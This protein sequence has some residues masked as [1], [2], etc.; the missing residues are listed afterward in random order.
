MT[1]QNVLPI[2]LIPDLFDEYAAASGGASVASG[3]VVGTNL[4]LTMS[5]ATSVVV[6]L[7]AIAPELYVAS[8]AL[9][10]TNLVLTMSDGS[11]VTIDMTAA[12]QSPATAISPAAANGVGAVGVSALYAREDHQHPAQGVSADAGNT[13]TIGT[14]GL[15]YLAS[16]I[17][18]ADAISPASDD[19]TGAIGVVAEAA[20]ED[21][22]HPA[23]GVS[24]DAGNMLTV[25]AD[26]LHNL[27]NTTLFADAVSPAADDAAG[28]IGAVDQAA[29]EDH[30]HPAQGVS[31]DAGNLLTVGTDGLHLFNVDEVIENAGAL[32]GA[33]PAGAQFGVDTTTGALYYVAAGNWTAVPTLSVDLNMTVSSQ[34]ASTAPAAPLGAPGAPDTGDIHLEIYSDFLVWWSWNGAAWA[35][36]GQTEIAPMMATAISP[37]ATNNVGAVGTSGLAAR[38]DH[39]HPAQGVSADANQ[40]ITVGADGLHF[41]GGDNRVHVTNTAVAPAAAGEPTTAEIAAAVTARDVI[42][43]YTGDDSAASTPTR[44]FHVDAAGVATAIF[45]GAIT[46]RLFSTYTDFIADAATVFESGDLIWV[47]N[48]GYVWKCTAGG[49]GYAAATFSLY[50]DNRDEGFGGQTFIAGT[51]TPD[52]V[53]YGHNY[54]YQMNADL[55]INAMQNA[56]GAVTPTN[57]YRFNFFIENTL[58]TAQNIIF[59]ASYLDEN[60]AALGTVPLAANTTAVYEF[61]AYN[62]A[63][64]WEWRRSAV[65]ATQRV[66]HTYVSQTSLSIDATTTFSSGDLVIVDLPG[67]IYE[68]TT[69]GVGSVAAFLTLI[70][71]TRMYRAADVSQSTGTLT[72]DVANTGYNHE[73]TLTGDLTI[74]AE[75]SG[76]LRNGDVLRFHVSNP[77]GAA[78]TVTF[79]AYYS[80]ESGAAMGAVVIADGTS[81]LFE[82]IQV[83][84][85]GASEN[86]RHYTG[87]AVPTAANAIAPASDDAVGA[88]GAATTEF[89]LEDHKHP[90]Q[91]VSADANN[92]LSVGADGLHMAD[93]ATIGADAISPA[94]DDATGAIG[95]VNQF[96]RED[97]KHPAQGISAYAVNQLSVGTDGLHFYGGS[98]IV[99]ITNTGTAPATAGSPTDAEA[100]A[101]AGGGATRDVFVR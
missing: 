96:A 47:Q 101:A 26:G 98:N 54:R 8:G 16:P 100:L 79:D 23:Q 4:I 95:T 81:E 10:G 43:Y 42:V 5:D 36:S 46:S 39:Q 97:H 91:G 90:A 63:G 92:L 38:E 74:A 19:A 94:A 17:V 11:T 25:G 28:L 44:V 45:V 9:T 15:H 33:A 30:K 14:D 67:Y 62:N 32:A 48:P 20:R 84:N 71:D 59:D 66:I 69:G 24:A 7:A 3:A 57:G 77:S 34:T 70:Q 83:Q 65:A 99:F 22:K 93:P 87:G 51:V 41:W 75:V 52:L 78:R 6:S 68:V 49:T 27:T 2:N 60:G 85:G 56:G 88:I 21:H 58:G 53:L 50:G 35:A 13:I 37:A 18:F 73:S 31:A 80:D 55:T 40:K 12:I 61:I 64:A 76:D 72:P 82:F 29:R 86:R 1:T 89:A